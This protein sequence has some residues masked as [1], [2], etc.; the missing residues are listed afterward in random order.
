M[1]NSVGERSGRV[2]TQMHT[3]AKGA[4]PNYFLKN[5]VIVTFR[6]GGLARDVLKNDS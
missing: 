2:T 4:S 6:G 5:N 1:L 3:A